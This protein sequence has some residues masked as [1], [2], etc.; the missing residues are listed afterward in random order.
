MHSHVRHDVVLQELREDMLA[1]RR[2][3]EETQPHRETLERSIGRREHCRHRRRI[4]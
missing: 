4:L 3:Q 2:E 1:E